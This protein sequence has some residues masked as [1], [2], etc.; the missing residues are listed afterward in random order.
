[1]WTHLE[2]FNHLHSTELDA[3]LEAPALITILVGAA[4]GE[5]DREERN[6]SDR[7]MRARTYNKPKHL[8]EY[9][10]IV[11]HGFLEKVDQKLG[12][13]PADVEARNTLISQ[14]LAALNPVL[15]KLDD[16]LGADLYK[17]YIGLAEETAKASGGFLRIGAISAEEARWIHLPMLTPIEGKATPV[18]WDE[19]DP[20]VED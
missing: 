4:D 16:P 2:G 20:E 19:K 12:E 5:L 1:M 11:A 3:L 7:L 8:N 15:E 6:W 14:K 9:Y 13:L 10:A 17:S 18:D